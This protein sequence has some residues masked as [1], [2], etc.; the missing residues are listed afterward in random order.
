MLQ[1]FN[2][3]WI[4]RHCSYKFEQVKLSKLLVSVGSGNQHSLQG[5]NAGSLTHNE[6]TIEFN[7]RTTNN[8]QRTTVFLRFHC[9]NY[10]ELEEM[11]GRMLNL[12]TI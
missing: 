6:G 5:N 3:E 12:Q 10:L 8:E 1:R 2:R 9:C 11:S 4:F 7:K